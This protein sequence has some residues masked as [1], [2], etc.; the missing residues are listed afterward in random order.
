MALIL[1]IETSTT[2][3]SVALHEDKKLI[4]VLEIHQEY[5]H[6]SKLASLVDQITKLTGIALD[7]L[8]CVAFSS[9]PGSYTG[10]RVGASLA[11]GLCYS[12]DI[13][14]VA[15]ST[16]EVLAHQVS[17]TNTSDVFLCPMLDARRMEV[18]C[19][20]FDHDLSEQAPIT[21]KI[22]DEES[23]QE[24]LRIK[25]IIFFGSGASKCS[26]VI[27][28]SNAKFLF[29]VYPS[30][31]QVGAL[32]FKK[33]EENKVEDLVQFVPLYLKEFFIKKKVTDLNELK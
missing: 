5:S 32:A 2:V 18:Y 19:Q 20:M 15:V 10:L 14:L 4:S 25:P 13:P 29:D 28:H 6:A 31:V 26:T 1:S 16:L 17:V 11:K 12:L 30:A 9:G 3:C 23:F 24:Y 27:S 8:N 22:V 21:S 7:Q 33:L